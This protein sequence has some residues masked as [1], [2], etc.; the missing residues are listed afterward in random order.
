MLTGF[1]TCKYNL[2]LQPFLHHRLPFLP[3]ADGFRAVHLLSFFI[4][5]PESFVQLAADVVH[6][7]VVARLVLL[8]ISL[9]AFDGLVDDGQ[10]LLIILSPAVQLHQAVVRIYMQGILLHHFLIELYGCS[11][12]A[13][14]FCFP[15]LLVQLFYRR[16]FIIH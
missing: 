6:V 8:V 9:I 11:R 10:F 5:K 4:R 1:N 12:I 14:D 15:S 2:L 7:F 13:I 3:C 16:C